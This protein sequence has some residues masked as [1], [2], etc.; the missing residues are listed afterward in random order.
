MYVWRFAEGKVITIIENIL[1]VKISI[2]TF[3]LYTE[4]NSKIWGTF[5]SEWWK[6]T[7]KELMNWLFYISSAIS[8]YDDQQT[9]W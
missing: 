3:I 8:D 4:K 5:V 2:N 9:S 6:I 1:L 7:Y